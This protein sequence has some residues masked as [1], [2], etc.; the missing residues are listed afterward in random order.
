MCLCLGVCVCING[1][2]LLF[3]YT[4]LIGWLSN[5]CQRRPHRHICVTSTQ[6][7][8]IHLYTETILSKIFYSFSERE[9]SQPQ[10]AWKLESS[11]R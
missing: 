4:R 2:L 7:E 11:H 6:T 5:P 9:T 3:E 10:S 8:P 1:W